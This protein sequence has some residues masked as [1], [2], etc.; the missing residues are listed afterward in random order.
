MNS[1]QKKLI[2]KYQ[3]SYHHSCFII[4]TKQ[5]LYLWKFSLDAKGRAGP[6]SVVNVDESCHPLWFCLLICKMCLIFKFLVKC[7]KF[8]WEAFLE[9]ESLE[10]HSKETLLPIVHVLTCCMLQCTVKNC[11]QILTCSKWEGKRLTERKM[12]FKP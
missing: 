7:F 4:F 3:Y 2:K 6:Y 8:Q 11:C 5:V 10:R 12:F 1:I 9:L